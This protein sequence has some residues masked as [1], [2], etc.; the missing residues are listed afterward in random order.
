MGT[1]SGRLGLTTY[2]AG[3]EPWSHTT[4]LSTIDTNITNILK[5]KVFAD[6]VSSTASAVDLTSLDAKGLGLLEFGSASGGN[7][8]TTITNGT[9]EQFLFVRFTNA[10]PADVIHGTGT[11]AITLQDATT[12]TPSQNNWIIL[13][14]DGDNAVWLEVL[15]S[16]ASSVVAGSID[17]T[18]IGAAAVGQGELKTA[19]EAFSVGA[20]SSSAASTAL[21]SGYC[22]APPLTAGGVVAYNHV[23]SGNPGYYNYGGSGTATFTVRYVTASPP[24]FI[25]GEEWGS[26][27]YVH[28]DTSTGE[29]LSYKMAPDPM[30]GFTGKLWAK[31]SP[32]RIAS[33]LPH[34]FFFGGDPFNG[35]PGTQEP[36]AGTEVVLVDLREIDLQQGVF[37]PGLERADVLR[38]MAVEKA[39]RGAP[40]NEVL[41]LVN[42]ADKDQEEALAGKLISDKEFLLRDM[43]ADLRGVSPF[44]LI[45]NSPQLLNATSQAKKKGK[46]IKFG[47]KEV[48]DLVTIVSAG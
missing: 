40:L 34:P 18:A 39:A 48:D 36:P 42:K 33:G 37:A 45:S 19:T 1:T 12:W 9:D 13:W 30:W 38:G 6:A 16:S 29:I 2:N 14:Y 25:D 28:R 41:D 26:F 23:G 7:D 10:S 20:S 11:D 43:R 15:R 27:L 21:A 32:E 17:Q 31:N 44:D 5:G 3:D 4:G 24:W 8:L 35:V 46:P 22:F 47:V